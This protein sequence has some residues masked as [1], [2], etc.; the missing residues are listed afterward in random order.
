LR[1]NLLE[2]EAPQTTVMKLLL[3]INMQ[4]RF[5][6]AKVSFFND[7]F[8]LPFGISESQIF[9]KKKNFL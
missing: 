4:K 7:N 5:T 6:S 9:V 2:V 8:K 1:N 3:L